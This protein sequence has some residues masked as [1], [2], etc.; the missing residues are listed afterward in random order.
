MKLKHYVDFSSA[1]SRYGNI[2]CHGKQQAVLAFPLGLN[3]K[4]L[5]LFMLI[6]SCLTAQAQ[7]SIHIVVKEKGTLQ[8]IE[9]AYITIAQSKQGKPLLNAFTNNKGS[10]TITLPQKG[11]Y[12]WSIK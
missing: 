2:S 11:T 3:K 5:L 4:I 7:H 12:V 10:A 9:A 6:I 8:P 1:S